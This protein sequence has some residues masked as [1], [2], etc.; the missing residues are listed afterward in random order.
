VLF[1]ILATSCS[2]EK[3]I[4]HETA[5]WTK[6]PHESQQISWKE[7]VKMI[8]SGKVIQVDQS[9]S[10]EVELLTNDYKRYKTNEPRLDDVFRIISEFDPKGNKIGCITE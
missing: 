2:S 10:Q 6:F 4:T 8:K 3:A 9:H 5:D 7:A 1:L